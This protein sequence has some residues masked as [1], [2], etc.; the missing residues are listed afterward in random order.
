MHVYAKALVESLIL[1]FV[2]SLRPGSG[3]RRTARV[4]QEVT[5][6]VTYCRLASRDFYFGKIGSDVR[7]RNINSLRPQDT[8]RP[9]GCLK[10]DQQQ[11]GDR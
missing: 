9:P 7:T 11:L 10:F 5:E 8:N 2:R 3:E 6:E 1:D 4:Y